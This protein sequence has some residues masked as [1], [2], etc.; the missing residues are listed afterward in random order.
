LRRHALFAEIDEVLHEAPDL[1]VRRVALAAVAELLA[2][3][4]TAVVVHPEVVDVVAEP[5]EGTLDE[6][7]LRRREAADEERHVVALLP[8]HLRLEHVVDP[9]LALG[10]DAE[11]LALALLEGLDLGLDVD[12]V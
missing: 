1:E 9:L 5:A 8:R 6:E 11:P 2:G 10:L 4:E 3:L 7:V 12:V